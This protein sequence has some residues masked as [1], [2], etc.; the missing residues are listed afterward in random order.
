VLIG[1]AAKERTM[2]HKVKAVAGKAEGA[3]DTR[4]KQPEPDFDKP[5]G[6]SH[7]DEADLRD[8]AQQA[9]KKSK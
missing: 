5:L 4:G 1:I 6:S 7:N 8:V 9:A 3:K 2:D